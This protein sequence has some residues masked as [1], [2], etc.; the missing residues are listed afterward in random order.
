MRRKIRYI[1]L[2]VPLF[3][4]AGALISGVSI[5]ATPND[6]CLECHGP[7]DK[8]AAAGAKYRAPSGVK[9]AKAIPECSNCH[10]PHTA[11]PTASDIAALP[12]PEV[13]WCYTTCHHENDFKPCKECH[14]Q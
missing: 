8:L 6:L 5:P 4:L 7:F 3:A 12:R 14:K 11:S 2:G 10:Q 13:Q 9:D 1:L